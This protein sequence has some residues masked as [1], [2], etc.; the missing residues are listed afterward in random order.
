M[1]EIRL[2][3]ADC[4]GVPGNC[5]YPH[6]AVI[7]DAASLRRAVSRD[8]VCVA[9]KNSYR[10]NAN[11]RTTNCLGMDCDND[12]SDNP[13]DW[14]TPE[15]VRSAFPDTT[16]AVHFS[17]NNMKEKRG[18][19]PR[20]KF[21]VLFLIDEITD[22]DE[23][24]DLKKR[25]SAVFPY[26]DTRALDAARF[27][28]GTETPQAEFCAGSI[29]LNECL[30]LYYPEAAEDAFWDLNSARATT[31]PEGRRNSTL[32]HFAGRVLKRYGDTEEAYA[33]FMERAAKCAPPLEDAEL[34]TIWRSAQGFYQRIS[35]EDNYVPPEEWNP[36]K[37][38][39]R[40]APDDRTDVGQARLLGHF[41]SH[42]LRY[43]PAT[44]FIR[45][46]GACWQETKPR[47][48]A[49]AHA[50]TDLQLED[51][52]SAV[53]DAMKRMA[54]NG[55]QH[56][57]IGSSRRKAESMMNEGQVEAFHAF[58]EAEA[59]RAY[60][61]KRR[62][63]K[64]ITAA[65]KEA[66]PVLE[67][68][69]GVLDRDWYLLCTPDA[70]YDLRK[71]LD[72]AREHRA[73]DFITRMTA[74]APGDRG[75]DIW[76]DALNTFFCGDQALI[77]YVQRVAGIVCVGQVFLEAMIIAYGD[78]RSGKSTFWNTLS[79]VMGSY[80]GNI[81]AD[82]LT[83]NCKRNVK[84][85]MAETKGKRLLIAAELEEGTRLNT[86]IVKQLCS[87]DSIFAEKKYKD[88]F[89]F[90]PS[91]TLV[92]YTNHLPRVVAKDTG[93]W[94]RLIVIPFR[95]KIEG[96]SDIKNYT[97]YLCENAGEAV[98]KWMIEGARQAIELGFKLPFPKCV[99]D[100]IEAYKAENDWLGH[101]LCECCE[102]ADGETARS[103]ELYS[104]YRAFSSAS[105]EYVRSTTDFYAA[106]EAEGFARQ[107]TRTG[108]IINGLRLKTH[109]D[110]KDEFSDFLS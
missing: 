89:S 62:E 56:L 109:A 12:H 104:T 60:A 22:P 99:S 74:C 6:E 63:S 53:A 50:L 59:Y 86:S 36:E 102:V 41:F 9:Y 3:Y 82:S 78:G 58:L 101:F 7:E 23:Y 84:P 19:A 30:E 15:H 70:T 42:E 45:Y 4:A 31:I 67:I 92:L 81:S 38:G 95:A 110:P 25:V 51:A 68:E 73:E 83:M 71:G 106:L 49:V 98:M 85:E 14:I 65:L 24:S 93:I 64:N 33:A 17:R 96:K 10:A 54:E 28:Y 39:F 35:Q 105:G 21:H 94:R 76:R 18:K 5:S 37:S 57:L 2:Y 43:S 91:H 44:D 108:N 90:T 107:R 66:Q 20:P 16:F 80:S 29:T 47:A 77:E 87:T 88:P 13:E 55:A 32:S 40:Y 61:L 97:E 34:K 1:A 100:A 69:P 27:F 52:E 8:Y 26:F 11:F 48:R 79:R 46:D 72:G 75:E 103:G